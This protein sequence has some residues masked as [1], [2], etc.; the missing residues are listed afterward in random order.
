MACFACMPEC[1]KCIPK[2][3]DCPQCGGKNSISDTL[4]AMCGHVF[5]S[6]ERKRAKAL[7]VKEL[8]KRNA[9]N[10]NR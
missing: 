4:C 3:I 2:F 9:P 6:D 7:W 8:M 5:T 1:D 10:K